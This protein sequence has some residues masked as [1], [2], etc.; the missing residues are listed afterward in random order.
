MAANVHAALFDRLGTD[1]AITT[2]VGTAP[3]K[4]FPEEA[5][6]NPGSRYIV[7]FR[8]G[9]TR[10][11]FSGAS[12][13][14]KRA[15]FQFNCYGANPDDARTLGDLVEARL[16]RASGTFATVVVQSIFVENRIEGV[17]DAAK[18]KVS[19]VDVDVVFEE[20]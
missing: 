9:K 5:A 19:I 18:L 1:A 13:T 3:K 17:D 20:A 2:I 15:R 16:N 7:Y 4:I 12:S 14:L 11:E 6:P 8:I 10:S